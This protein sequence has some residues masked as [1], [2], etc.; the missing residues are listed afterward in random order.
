MTE[1]EIPKRIGW[2]M[3]SVNSQ[4]LFWKFEFMKFGFVSDFDIR[5]SDL[6]HFKTINLI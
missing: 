3:I 1:I 5:A 4:Y 2:T 6:Y